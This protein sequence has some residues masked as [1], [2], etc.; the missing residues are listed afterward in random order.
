MN[1]DYS[2]PTVRGIH[3]FPTAENALHTYDC[4][5][6][7]VCNP[8]IEYLDPDTLLPYPRGPLVTHTCFTGKPDE[9]AMREHTVLALREARRDD[10][11]EEEE[12]YS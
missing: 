7:C 10:T 12:A 9:Q 11:D 3:I 4:T 8:D 1:I 5:A 2:D 6:P